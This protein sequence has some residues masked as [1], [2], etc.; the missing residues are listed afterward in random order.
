[1]KGGVIVLGVAEAKEVIQQL[2]QEQFLCNDN[3]IAT[4]GYVIVKKGVKITTDKIN[5]AVKEIKEGK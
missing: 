2:E 1:M 5:N 4:S 3:L